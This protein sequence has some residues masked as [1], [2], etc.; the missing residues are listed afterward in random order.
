MSPLF[1]IGV[2]LMLASGLYL[3]GIA[4]SRLIADGV[5]KRLNK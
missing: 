5:A 1:L 2:I 3:M 4:M